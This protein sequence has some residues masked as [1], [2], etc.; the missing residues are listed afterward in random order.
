MRD[1]VIM[2]DSCCDMTAQMAEELELKVLPLSLLMG[3]DTYRNWLDGREIGF[4]DFYERIRSGATATTSAISVGDFEEAMRPILE[5]GK[6]ILYLGFSSGLSTTYQSSAIA[7]DGLREEFPD[8]K[9]YT[10]DSLAASLGLSL[11]L[12]GLPSLL[13]GLPALTAT[14]LSALG[15]AV[16]VG[17]WLL[18][19]AA[20]NVFSRVFASSEREKHL[21][22]E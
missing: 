17:L 18:C 6:D 22:K 9:I 12:S 8:A 1:F 11:V 10:V 14:L 5:A 7:A 4:H 21:Y 16:G 2:T 19:L 13:W 20:K 15:W 3:E